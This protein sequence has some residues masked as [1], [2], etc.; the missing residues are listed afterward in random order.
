[1]HGICTCGCCSPVP[2]VV[3]CFPIT[4]VADRVAVQAVLFTEWQ[5]TSVIRLDLTYQPGEQGQAL[6]F[7]YCAE[8]TAR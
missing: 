1:M 8:C 6:S 4:V 2:V 7:F 5:V 3:L